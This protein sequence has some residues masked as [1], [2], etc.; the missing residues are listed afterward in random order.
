MRTTFRRLS[1]LLVLLAVGAACAEETTEQREARL[2]WWREARFGL[3]IHWGVYSV[4]AGFYQDTPVPGIGEWIMNRGHIPVASYR[5]FAKQ[6]NPIKYDPEAWVKL[7][8][9]AGMKYLVITAKHHDGFALFDSAASDWN[10]VK[11]SPYGRDLLKPLAAACAKEGIR[12]GFYYSQAQDWNNPGGAAA[13]GQWDPAQ[14][15]SMDDYLAK[16][17]VPQ[18]RELLTNY[19]PLSILWWDTP[20]DMTPARAKPLADLMALQPGIITN[21]RLG[22]GY[23]G[24]SETPEQFIPATGY[25]GRDWE[26][27]MTMNDTWGFKRDDH[28]W[29]P[30]GTL[31][32][33]LVDIASKGGNYL[34]NVGPNSLG[35][36]PPESVERLQAVG[37]WMAVNG[38]AIY[39][40]SASPFKRLPWG[41]ATRV[42]G[43]DNAR[44]YLHV[45]DW[46]ADGKLLVPGLRSDITKA[47]LLN[48]NAQTGLAV[49]VGDAG[50]VIALPATAP[51]A[52]SSTVVVQTKGKLV[53]EP[54]L[55]RQAADGSLTLAPGDAVIHG[56]GLQVES[57]H[58]GA[59]LGFWTDPADWVEWSFEAVKPGRLTASAEVASEGA[60]SL[61]VTLGAQK[62][63]V[64]VPNTGG[65]AKFVKIDLGAFELAAAGKATLAVRPVKD[66]WSPVNLRAVKLVP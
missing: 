5:D 3:F 60:A 51:D 25:P 30:V 49:T 28:N 48:D 46:P 43:D 55:L 10:V 64:K 57:T 54:T 17:A 2:R 18:V 8:K 62:Q 61:E 56:T 29:K 12:L 27:C 50:P 63:V 39:A 22:G 44:L 20:V 38:E 65:Y 16:V 32:R 13:G 37:R 15:G 35:E 52:I 33:N 53:I 7:A 41:R 42:G 23:H 24:D 40:T 47:W 31:I 45:F 58:G 4:P 11:A 36:I 34:L 59:N 1:I 9:A 26:T 14:K 21:N 66:S 19:G 6:F